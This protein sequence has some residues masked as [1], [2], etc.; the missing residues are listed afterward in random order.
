MKS[1][2]E[3]LK[4]LGFNESASLGSQKA[5]FR[6]LVKAA[7]ESVAKDS[8]VEADSKKE[9]QVSLKS[10]PLGGGEQRKEVQLS[11]PLEDLWPESLVSP[12]KKRVS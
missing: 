9:A 8:L 1:V 10:N 6:H 5:F 2:G 3:I 12:K 7:Q 11:F 4:E